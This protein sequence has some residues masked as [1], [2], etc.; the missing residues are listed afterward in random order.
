VSKERLVPPSPVLPDPERKRVLKERDKLCFACP[1]SY[2]ASY[3]SCPRCQLPL[4]FPI[5]GRTWVIEGLLGRGGMGAVFAAHHISTPQRKAAVK[6]LV[7]VPGEQ[8]ADRRD[9]I[10]RFHREAL[11]LRR[12]VHDNIVGLY[13]FARERDGS[14]YLAMER[15]EGPTLSALVKSSGALPV[16]QA[17]E[18]ILP[19]LSAVGAAHKVGV[20]HRDLKPD[21][22]VLATVGTGA[23]RKQVIK[24]VDFGVARLAGDTFTRTGQA[25]GTPV[26]MP[27]EQANGTDIDERVDIYGAGAVLYELLTGRPPFVA[28]D[29]PNANLAVLAMVVTSEPRPPREIQKDVPP[30]LDAVVLR[31]MRRNRDERFPSVDAFAAAIREALQN[32]GVVTWAPPATSAPSAHSPPLAPEALPS[33]A[34]DSL[35]VRAAGALP[36]VP[37]PLRAP[38]AERPL[39]PAAAIPAAPLPG[40]G[41]AP[42]PAAP[43]GAHTARI[44][45]TGRPP[46]FKV[47]MAIL[48]LVLVGA[49]VIT[50]L[51]DRVS[52]RQ[53]QTEGNAETL[54]LRGGSPPA[55][56][57]P[58]REEGAPAGAAACPPEMVP[59]PAGCFVMG[60]ADE[61][62]DGDERPPHEVCLSRAY[63]I[64]RH[65][66]D[67]ASY[68]AC[69]R[70]G[71]CRQP[72]HDF[73]RLQQSA[74][75][76]D[77]QPVVQVNWNDADAY[78]RAQ[79]KRLPTEAEW[80]YAARGADGRLYPWGTQPPTCETAVLGAYAM[81]CTDSWCRGANACL[82]KNP[83]HPME[84]GSR[85]QDRSPFGA[86]DMGGNV[87]EWV[88]DWYGE[89]YY[90]E[91]PRNDPGGPTQ[92]SERVYR[93]GSWGQMGK[94]VRSTFRNHMAPD[95]PGDIGVGFRCAR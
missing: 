56:P 8:M 28:P 20:I 66:V 60:S 57:R 88:A 50:L 68:Q 90:E 9:R 70:K 32:P 94:T 19:V 17:V 37:L 61:L 91:S 4:V 69:V 79:G 45:L 47:L 29:A 35:P 30:A 76:A 89:R 65:E 93:G 49:L 43:Q 86:I 64:D 46:R 62:A 38:S 24:V 7:P 5:I 77:R 10:G 39:E 83:S 78:C 82:G 73:R 63:C 12:L 25:L 42:H 53:A 80:E 40:P 11:A 58:A 44:V 87:S 95:G 21:N 84:S 22:I 41:T 2:P 13:D 85:P 67:N 15:L 92:G 26:Y 16:S 3:S 74:F 6:V 75:T 71:Q 23:A 34:A 54:R 72:A 1:A 48:Y 51:L 55:A 36:N 33:L 14:L 18:L 59:V 31:A 81:V 27:P 52:F